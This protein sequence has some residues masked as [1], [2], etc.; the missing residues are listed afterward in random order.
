[1]SATITLDLGAMLKEGRDQSITQ[2]LDDLLVTAIEG[3]SAYWSGDCLMDGKFAASGRPWYVNAFT[4][5]MTLKVSEVDEETGNK[6]WHALDLAKGIAGLQL[7]ATTQP[8]RF[9]SI[10]EGQDDADD[11]DVWLQL[12]TL[13]EVR[14]G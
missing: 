2:V 12:S 7:L 11:A 13:G 1:M 8:K 3:G 10:L 14:Y 4:D 5:G 9:V 6:E